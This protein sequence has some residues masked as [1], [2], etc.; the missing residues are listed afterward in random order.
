[1]TSSSIS[2]SGATSRLAVAH[3]LVLAGV[4]LNHVPYKG[5][6]HGVGTLRPRRFPDTLR[7]PAVSPKDRPDARE[8]LSDTCARFPSIDIES[9]LW[10]W[11]EP[12]CEAP[13]G[14]EWHESC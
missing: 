5:S 11:C 9:W 10:S 14:V 8:Q 4:K 1:M 6:P 13:P 7:R 2:I 12:G 3:Y